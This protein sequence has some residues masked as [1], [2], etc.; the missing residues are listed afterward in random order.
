MLGFGM[1]S[2]SF[3]RVGGSFLVFFSFPFSFGELFWGTSPFWPPYSATM[4]LRV[5]MTSS[6][7]SLGVSL[8]GHLSQGGPG[9]AVSS[10]FSALGAG[11]EAVGGEA[12]ILVIVLFI[13]TPIGA[14]ILSYSAGRFV[15]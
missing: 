6:L 4:R 1:F 11:R 12:I 7:G 15:S 3:R 10:V 14:G 9:L 2:D 5:C 8:K 13:G